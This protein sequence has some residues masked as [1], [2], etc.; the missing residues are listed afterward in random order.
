LSKLLLISIIVC[1]RA[2]QSNEKPSAVFKLAGRP[3]TSGDLPSPT[4]FAQFAT[5]PGLFGAGGVS[6]GPQVALIGLSL[7]PS[8][9]LAHYTSAAG[10]Q[11]D[12]APANMVTFSRKM[13]ESFFAFLSSFSIVGGDGRE[14]VP[15]S[16]AHQ[17]LES[18]D[19]KLAA[20]PFF[21]RS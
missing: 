20:N 15:L 13:L 12:L 9:Q 10:A 5:M 2:T 8:E 11:P 3:R 16:A 6:P 21:W 14:Y 17:W 7:E 18:F 19:R 1:S 4:A